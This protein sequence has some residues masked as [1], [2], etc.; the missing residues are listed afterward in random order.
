MLGLVQ[1]LKFLIIFIYGS[2]IGSLSNMLIDRFVER[3]TLEEEAL[4]KGTEA[5]KIKKKHLYFKNFTYSCGCI[6]KG[7][8]LI[9]VMG[10]FLLK[11]KCPECGKKINI[12]YMVVELI[13]GLTFVVNVLVNG[14]NFVSFFN[15]LVIAGLII[16]TVVD[17][18]K[19]E[20][21]VEI[22]YFI[23]IVGVIVSIYDYGNLSEHIIGMFA[24]SLFTYGLMYFG[25]M[26]GGDVKLMFTCGLLLGWKVIIVSFIIGCILGSIIH[27]IR[28]TIEK[29]K[30]MLAFG[31]YLSMGVF[32]G[33]LYGPTIIEWYMGYFK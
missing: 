6:R 21:P 22:N 24:I 20:I 14:F 13:T 17:F 2:T 16:L 12:R 32:V 26:G 18:I 5:E 9:P 31:P 29:E 33:M 25:A 7:V 11:G 4:E 1:I 10:Y 28:M 30:S 23:L 27:S 8:A 19:Y 3:I 15:C